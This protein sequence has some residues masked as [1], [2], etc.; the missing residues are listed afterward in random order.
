MNVQGQFIEFLK[1]AADLDKQIEMIIFKSIL[2]F[3][4]SSI[5]FRGSW[6]SNVNWL[7]PKIEPQSANLDRPNSNAV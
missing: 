3:L 7:Q 2:T 1:S 6:G 5:I 4:K